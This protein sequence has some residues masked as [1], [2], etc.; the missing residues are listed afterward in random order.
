V[1]AQVG[2]DDFL[3]S[4]PST[5]FSATTPEKAL[6]MLAAVTTRTR[7]RL[8][9]Q[10]VEHREAWFFPMR[11]T[12]GLYLTLGEVCVNELSSYP[13]SSNLQNKISLLCALNLTKWLLNTRCV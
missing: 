3:V 5:S 12:L 10:S 4:N 9:E 13:S 1:F 6:M 11:V 2:D 8:Q 7:L